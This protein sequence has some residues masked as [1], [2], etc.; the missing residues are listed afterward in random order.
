MLATEAPVKAE[1]QEHLNSGLSAPA[2]SETSRRCVYF[3]E[4][5]WVDVLD[6]SPAALEALPKKA[7]LNE[8][9]QLAPSWGFRIVIRPP[10]RR[11][12]SR[13]ARRDDE[14]EQKH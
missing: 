6:L 10:G 9:K 3:S 11:L 5:R 7:S 14:D 8:L 4:D 1:A 12:Q 13:A 2:G